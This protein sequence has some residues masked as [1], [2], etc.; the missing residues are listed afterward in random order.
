MGATT[1]VKLPAS[2]SVYQVATAIG[3]L[4]GC[5]LTQGEHGVR[6][7]GVEVK[8]ATIP[9]C[10]YIVVPYRSGKFTYLFHHEFERDGSRGLI[11][12]IA[13][14][15]YIMAR[16]LVQLFGGSVDYNDCD[17]RDSN[18]RAKENP[19]LKRLDNDVAWRKFQKQLRA[20]KPISREEIAKEN[21]RKE[22]RE[23]RL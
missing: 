22:F 11:L 18:Y 20:L 8:P 23:L 19:L 16:R 15:N 10:S 4:H 9:T 2:A 14:F 13:A 1:K 3:I 21:E 7:N 6:V 17:S 12:S 5:A